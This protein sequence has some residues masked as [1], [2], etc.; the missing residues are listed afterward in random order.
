MAGA[1]VR[2]P[3]PYQDGGLE[4]YKMYFAGQSSIRKSKARLL[5][6]LCLLHIFLHRPV[7]K[8]LSR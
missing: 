7:L 2:S 5:V 8:M 4:G 1:G 3:A 6:A